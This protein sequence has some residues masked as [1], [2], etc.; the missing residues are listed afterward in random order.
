MVV[1]SMNDINVA[2]ETA[3]KC[4]K[5]QVIQELYLRFSQ[6]FKQTNL[7]TMSADSEAHFLLIAIKKINCD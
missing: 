1:Y 3:K 5:I 4:S 2:H 6:L 7:L